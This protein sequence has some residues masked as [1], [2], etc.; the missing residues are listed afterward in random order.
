MKQATI[1]LTMI[2]GAA[3]AAD[4]G[5]TG[6]M[7]TVT[8]IGVLLVLG[9]LVALHNVGDWIGAKA[10]LTEEQARSL[11]LDNDRKALEN[12]KLK[13]E[14]AALRDTTNA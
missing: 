2:S 7:T 9:V 11:E 13:L 3:Y 6:G 5:V 1:L 12:E 8:I 14:V 4:E 10:K